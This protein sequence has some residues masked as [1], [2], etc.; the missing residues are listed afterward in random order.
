DAAVTGET[1]HAHAVDLP[2][3]VG[4]GWIAERRFDLALLEDGQ[5]FHLIEAGAAD[6]ADACGVVH[7]GRTLLCGTDSLID[8]A[9]GSQL[10]FSTAR[11]RRE[12]IANEI[13]GRAARG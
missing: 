11:G 5:P 4:I 12:I 6:D 3:D 1:S 7:C 9:G 13:R 10:R 2:D 8:G